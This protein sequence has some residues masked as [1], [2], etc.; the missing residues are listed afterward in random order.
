VR[1]VQSE[2]I[3]E[4][5]YAIACTVEKGQQ[6]W[7]CWDL[8]HTNSVDIFPGR[9]GKLEFINAGYDFGKV[10]DGDLVLANFPGPQGYIEELA[11]W[12]LFIIFQCIFRNNTMLIESVCDSRHSFLLVGRD[13][14]SNE[15]A[16]TDV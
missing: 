2:N 7:S 11:K 3:L 5:A 13:Y 6:I 1:A 10:R 8:G 15:S 16:C 14:P 4:S 12:D 9:N